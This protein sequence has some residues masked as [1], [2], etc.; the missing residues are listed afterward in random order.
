M[1]D[2]RVLPVRSAAA[3][4]WPGG[5]KVESAPWAEGKQ[6]LTRSYEC[7]DS[8]FGLG[9]RTQNERRWRFP[10]RMTNSP[11]QMWER[12]SLILSGVMGSCNNRAPVASNTAL[13]I[14]PPI[15]IMGGSPPP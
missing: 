1:G 2:S 4:V 8:S 13:A 5:V 14:N 15:Q 9:R 3:A 10:L 12:A 11:Y 6:T 7:R